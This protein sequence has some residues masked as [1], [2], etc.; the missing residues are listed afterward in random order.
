MAR[1]RISILLPIQDDREAGL[2]SVQ[3]WLR[4]QTAAGDLYELIALAPGADRGLENAVRPLL[5]SQDRWLELDGASSPELFNAGAREARGEFIFLTESH[6]VPERDCVEAMLEELDRTGAAGVRGLDPPTARGALGELERDK[7]L[8]EISEEEGPGHWRRVL[9]HSLALRRKIYLDAGGLPPR[10]GDF[11]AWVLAM[12]LD[13]RGERVAFSP[14]PR[15]GHVY[16]GDL[17]HVRDHLI[18]FGRGEIR[19]RDDATEAVA[20]RYLG[21]TTEWE[22]QLEHTRVGAWRGLRAAVALRH[23]GALRAALRHLAVAI[24]GPRASIEAARAG[25]RVAELSARLRPGDSRRRADRFNDFWRLTARRG[26]LQGLA[27]SRRAPLEPSK[28]EHIDLTESL[29]GRAIGFHD[30]EPVDGE[31]PIRWT[32]ALALIRVD[33]PDGGPRRARLELLP[34]ERPAEARP[35]R[36]RIAVDDRVVPA[37]EGERAI[38]FEIEPGSHW[39]AVACTPLRPRTHGVND[40]RRIGLPVRSLRFL[41]LDA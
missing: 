4:E 10:Y 23:R 15:V 18:T 30:P 19:F 20:A 17:S 37:A 16:D 41:K 32:T 39:I 6:C 38:E 31:A 27:E 26:R 25:A 2:E 1:P 13:G 8:E 35:A 14:R 7:F 40:H 22:E 24:L 21:L 11:G 29:A 5:R 33:V 3:S 9:V 12:E 36:P 34:L 28:E